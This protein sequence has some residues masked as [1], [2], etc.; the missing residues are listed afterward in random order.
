MMNEAWKPAESLDRVRDEVRNAVY[1][2]LFRSLAAEFDGLPGDKR[3]GQ[4]RAVFMLEFGV[5]AGLIS[6]VEANEWLDAVW[7]RK[8]LAEPFM[9]YCGREKQ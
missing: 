4:N 9:K 8:P 3:L 5:N 6:P 2:T 7:E 1:W